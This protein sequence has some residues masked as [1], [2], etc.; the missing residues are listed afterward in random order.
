MSSGRFTRR[1]VFVDTSALGA[2]VIKRDA[3]N[4]AAHIIQ[5]RLQRERWLLATSN[6][7][8]AELHA[9]IL[10][11]AEQRLTLRVVQE[12]LESTT[13]IERVTERDERRALDILTRY[14]DKDFS[15]TDATSFAVM[16]R[17]GIETAF[18]F[19]YHFG[20]YGFQALTAEPG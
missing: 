7:I 12:I 18:T 1:A 13:R 15:Y 17:L 16:E 11:R 4:K 14:T 3:Y 2:Y 9:F 6:F 20:Q 10:R 19:D 5:D 8:L